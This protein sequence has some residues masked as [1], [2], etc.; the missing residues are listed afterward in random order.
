MSPSRRAELAAEMSE[1]TRQLAL[2]GIRQRHPEYS[3]R[4]CFMALMRMIHGDVLVQKA[5]PDESLRA[6]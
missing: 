5:W 6:G 1:E 3:E 2:D 4:D